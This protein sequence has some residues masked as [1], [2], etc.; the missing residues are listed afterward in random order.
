MSN[1]KRK[2]PRHETVLQ[3]KIPSTSTSCSSS[4]L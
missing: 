2:F 4:T 1:Y 3:I